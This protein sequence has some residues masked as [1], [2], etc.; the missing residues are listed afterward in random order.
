VLQ[1]L[2]RKG[3]TVTKTR[4]QT[5]A[6]DRRHAGRRRKAGPRVYGTLLPFSGLEM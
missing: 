6:E 2:E 4:I 3:L 1:R 5:L